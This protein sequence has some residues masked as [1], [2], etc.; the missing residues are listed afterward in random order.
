MRTNVRNL[1]CLEQEIKVVR[2]YNSVGETKYLGFAGW[3]LNNSGVVPGNGA[4]LIQW[5][6]SSTSTTQRAHSTIQHEVSKNLK[7]CVLNY[8]YFW[9]RV[10][11]RF[12]ENLS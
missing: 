4:C 9:E 6:L 7:A 11:M 3:N 12:S 10:I 1:S 2:C 8:F 5:A